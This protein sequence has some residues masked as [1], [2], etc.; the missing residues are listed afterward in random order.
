VIQKL[1]RSMDEGLLR[2]LAEVAYRNMATIDKCPQGRHV[3]AN[4]EE[5]M[6]WPSW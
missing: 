1:V 4:M 3:I 6:S 2:V 5:G